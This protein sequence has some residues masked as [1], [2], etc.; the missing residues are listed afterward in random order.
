[1]YG[2][3]EIDIN[4]FNENIFKLIGEKWMLIT[5]GNEK[6]LNTMTASWGGVGVLWSKNVSFAFIRP[7]RYTFEFIEENEYSTRRKLSR[8]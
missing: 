7:Q 4:S 3:K 2:F 6:K 8:I 1:M 5:A